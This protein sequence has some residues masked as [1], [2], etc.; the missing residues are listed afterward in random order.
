MCPSPRRRRID[1]SSH[2]ALTFRGDERAA[3]HRRRRHDPTPAA[4][5]W[6]SQPS[7]FTAPCRRNSEA[8][9]RTAAFPR[10]TTRTALLE[11]L[12]DPPS[13]RRVSPPPQCPCFSR[14]STCLYPFA[15]FRA[16]AFCACD[17]RPRFEGGL[18][19]SACN[20]LYARF[21]L[22]CVL[23]SSPAPMNP[24]LA[25]TPPLQGDG[26]RVGNINTSSSRSPTS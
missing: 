5:A 10:A 16:E 18:D 20:S 2:Q 3:P 19:R 21:P 11:P 6:R 25:G 24:A 7:Y 17:F 14:P 9:A 8:P 26:L 13:P 1:V 12:V 23:R 15:H 4:R 22:Y